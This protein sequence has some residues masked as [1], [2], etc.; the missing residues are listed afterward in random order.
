MIDLRPGIAWT[1]GIDRAGVAAG[2]AERGHRGCRSTLP[3]PRGRAD[4]RAALTGYLRRS[5][6]VHCSA[7]QLVVTR[8]VAGSL[9]LLASAL[10]RPGDRVGVEEPGY[11]PRGPCSPRTGCASCRARWTRAAS[12]RGRAAGRPAAGLRDP[13]APVSAGRP[14]VGAAQA[15]ADLLGQGYRR[16]HR[17]G[18]LRRR[19]PLRRRAAAGPVRPGPRGRGV[20]GNDDEDPHPGAADRLAGRL[21]R[22][23]R[24]AGHGRR[25]PGRLGVRAR[26]GRAAQ[27]DRHRCAGTAHP[28]DAARLCPA[29]VR[30]GRGIPAEGRRAADPATRRACT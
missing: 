25:H 1:E 20:P 24:T 5:R 26:P 15:G 30:H 17:G 13:G 6:G 16:A 14:A 28:A 8:G 23:G 18:R 21:A 9:G 10:L 3:D 22:A 29:A 2:L 11:P 4:L 12:G 7:G 19:V 27:H